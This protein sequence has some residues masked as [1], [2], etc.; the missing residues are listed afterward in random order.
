VDAV[1]ISNT[2]LS[3][4]PLRSRHAGEQGGLSGKP[5]FALSTRQLAKFH[6]LS[7]GRVPLIGAGGIEDAETAWTKILAGASLLQVYSA[8]VYQGPALVPMIL[9]GLAR[10]LR[11][12]HLISLSE[13]VGLK[14]ADYAQG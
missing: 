8:L 12:N 13:A 1:I 9:D 3:R 6:Q 14:S 11:E 10:K 5:L 4:P 7:G 2:T